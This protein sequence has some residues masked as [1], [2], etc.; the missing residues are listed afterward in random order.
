M[1]KTLNAF[2]IVSAIF[3]MIAA[4]W[5]AVSDLANVMG[6]ST[7]CGIALIIF[8][9]VS[10]LAALSSGLKSSGSGWLMFDG[11]ISF[12]C[13]LAYIFWYVDYALF[14]VDL[15]YIMGLWLMFLGISQIART[16]GRLTLAL[17]VVKLTGF[18]AILGGLALYLKP[19]AE[20]LQ[21]SSGGFLQVYSTSFRLIIAALLVISRLLLRNGSRK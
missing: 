10:M 2:W 19:A 13:G 9:V 20:L 8:G 12:L 21:M 15:T 4:L 3:L 14:T 5:G 7:V 11:V 17:F 1:K 18:L 6:A 16:S